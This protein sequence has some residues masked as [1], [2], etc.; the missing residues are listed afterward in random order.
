[1]FRRIT[2][3]VLSVVLAVAA[4]TGCAGNNDIS[5]GAGAKNFP[6]SIPVSGGSVTISQEPAGVAVLSPNIASVI[7][8]LGSDYEMKLKAKSAACTQ[9]DLS[10]LP[11]VTADDADKIK[12]LGATLVF[13][14]SVTDAQAAAF[15]KDGITILILKPAASRTVLPGFTPRS[16]PHS[17]GRIPGIK[18]ARPWHKAFSRR[19]TTSPV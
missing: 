6:V 18:R 16:A 11:D 2:A 14:D 9:S 13:A 17:K 3:A 12:S 8:S 5:K 1:M 19:L 10:V 15:Q 4:F 7:L